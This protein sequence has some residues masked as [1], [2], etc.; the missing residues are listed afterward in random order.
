MT[1]RSISLVFPMYNE[2]EYLP[3]AV[4]TATRV[5]SGIAED[6]EIIIVD[7]A[8][9][10]DSRQIAEALSRSDAH[11]RVIHHQKNRKL[12]GALKTGFYAASKEAVIYTDID[13][14]FDL[15][16]LRN[17]IPLLSEA[18]IVIGSRIGGRESLVRVIYSW[19]YNRL[20]NLVFGLGVRD[21]NFAL[22]VFRRKIL[23]EMDLQAEGSF[24]NAEF[25][26]KARRLGYRIKEHQVVYK[27]RSYGISRLS[28]LPVIAKILYEMIRLYPGLLSF[29]RRRALYRR[30]R[31]RYRKASLAARLYNF[32]RFKTCPF[33]A[34]L[35]FIPAQ[36]T[37]LDLGCGT[38][39]FLH[40]LCLRGC[41]RRLIGIDQDERK[42]KIARTADADGEPVF[43]CGDILQDTGALA[44]QPSCITL[45]DVLYSMDARVKK[46]VI[47]RC[48]DLLGPGGVL[49]VK[50]AGREPV[51]KFFWM[52]VQEFLMRNVFG[53]SRT[54]GMYFADGDTY[55]TLMEES[56]FKTHVLDLSRGYWYPHLLLV[57]TKEG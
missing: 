35:D 3:L 31:Q 10:D 46:K 23:P 33:D 18:D 13:L 20:I 7:D 21:V 17:A 2:R 32:A 34:I 48:A 27:V 25:L 11:I 15:E 57:G 38:G 44:Q 22:K 54:Q 51:L 9:T 30:L 4:Q 45:I 50:D 55:R 36:G 14:P 29:N 49:V 6:Y 47:A 41:G 52:F 24:I 26:V 8:S 43:L 16:E 40:L 42:L 12:G 28:T 56:G 37:V 1:I 53:V 39:I 5:L 19:V